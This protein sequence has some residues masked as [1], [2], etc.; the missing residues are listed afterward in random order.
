M[1]T[2]KTVKED[3]NTEY[4]TYGLTGVCGTTEYSFDDISDKKEHAEIIDNILS[5]VVL[6]KHLISRIAF[7]IAGILTEPEI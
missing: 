4:T 2:M 5:S 3:S 7:C 6:P 1:V